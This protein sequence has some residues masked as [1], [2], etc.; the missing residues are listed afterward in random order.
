MMV[1][2][3]RGKK[4]KSEVGVERRNSER[5]EEIEIPGLEIAIIE[6]AQVKKRM[7]VVMKL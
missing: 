7:M 2:R 3:N 5:D 4:K 6:K 1:F